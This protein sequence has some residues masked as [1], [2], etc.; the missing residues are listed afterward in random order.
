MGRR[1]RTPGDLGRGA[2]DLGA[3]GRRALER[4]KG[5]LDGNVLVLNDLGRDRLD[6]CGR[7]NYLASHERGV[8]VCIFRSSLVHDRERDR[9]PSLRRIRRRSD[10]DGDGLGAAGPDAQV[11]TRTYEEP[12]GLVAFALLVHEQRVESYLVDL[13]SSRRGDDAERELPFLTYFDRE[14]GRRGDFDDERAESHG[15]SSRMW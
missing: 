15:Q 11:A 10:G 4:G 6:R 9:V 2:G 8:L 7:S 13:T 12:V 5:I 1:A 3:L 14:L